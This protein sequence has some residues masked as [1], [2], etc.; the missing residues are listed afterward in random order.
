MQWYT[1]ISLPFFLWQI[2]QIDDFYNQVFP[3]EELQY[4]GNNSSFFWDCIILNFWNDIVAE[5][6]ESF[7]IKLL[8]K[9]HIYNSINNVDINEDKT[10]YISREFLQSQMPFRLSLFRLNL[11]VGTTII[12][13]CNL[14][15]ASGE[16]NRT[17]MII[18]WFRRHCIGEFYSQ[19]CLISRIKLTTTKS[20]LSYILS[21][22]QYLIRLYF[23]MTINKSQGPFLKIVGVDLQMSTFTHSQFYIALLQ[24]TSTQRVT[25]LFSEN[26]DKKIINIVYLEVL[27]QLL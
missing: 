6:N 3:L 22:Q 27:L 23:A 10:D 17:Q 12:L 5:F 20:D 2:S 4:A 8:K 9:I 18:I 26:G 11:K 19:L 15:P 13:L 16:Y 7:L 1:C 25:V 24:V 21:Q 14:Y